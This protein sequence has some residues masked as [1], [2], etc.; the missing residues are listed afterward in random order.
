MSEIKATSSGTAFK[1][2]TA[3]AIN[4]SAKPEKIMALLASAQKWNSTVVSIK[5][6]VKLGNTVKLKSVL[7]AK[8]TFN[9]KVTTL[10][11]T[12]LVWEDG[13]APMFKGVRTFTLLPK[14][15]GT[16]DFSMVEVFNGI[17]L[18]LIKGSL[19]DFKPNFEKYATDLKAEAE[20]N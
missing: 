6:E 15:D 13:F 4:I 3:V 2:Q 19:P 16:T 17:M 5:G 9:L 1:M 10:T 20:K 14:Q 8:R 11:P 7:D 18:P 12:S